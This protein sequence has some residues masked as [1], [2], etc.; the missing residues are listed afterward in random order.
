MTT[1]RSSNR[2]AF[3]YT[4]LEVGVALGVGAA[5]VGV[6]RGWFKGGPTRITV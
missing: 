4:A 6:V 5:Q 1:A 3:W 2:R